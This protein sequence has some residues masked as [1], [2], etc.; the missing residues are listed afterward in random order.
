MDFQKNENQHMISQMVRDFAK[1]EIEPYL[2]EWDEDQ[3][4]P[5]ELF[6]KL[7]KFGLMGILVPE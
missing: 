4:F 6:K 5:I 3:I 2:M 1:K 7:G